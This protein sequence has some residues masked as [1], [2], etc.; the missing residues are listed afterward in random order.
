MFFALIR[1]KG[2]KE[3]LDAYFNALEP[4]SNFKTERAGYKLIKAKGKLQIEISA[5]DATAFRAVTNTIVGL[6]SIV[7]KTL[8][9]FRHPAKTHSFSVVEKSVRQANGSA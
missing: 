2:T 8:R 9:C 5:E 7:A 1:I 4:E 3:E 6:I